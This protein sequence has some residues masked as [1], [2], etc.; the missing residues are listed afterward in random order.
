[1]RQ[2]I[3][4]LKHAMFGNGRPGIV[5]KLTRIEERV[6]SIYAI[7]KWVSL[8]GIPVA[9]AVVIDTLKNFQ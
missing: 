6:G 1:M 3:E 4:R 8:I 2:D 9:G 7:L 5:E